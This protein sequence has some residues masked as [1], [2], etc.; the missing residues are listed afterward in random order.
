VVLEP[1]I[2]EAV[3]ARFASPYAGDRY[4]VSDEGA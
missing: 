1:K 2:R 4:V 3:A